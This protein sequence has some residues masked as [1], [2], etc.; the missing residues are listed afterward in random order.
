M[1]CHDE[2]PRTDTDFRYHETRGFMDSTVRQ[3]PLEVHG[4]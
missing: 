3:Q 4:I 1:A 2:M